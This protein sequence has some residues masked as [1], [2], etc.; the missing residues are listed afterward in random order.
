MSDEIETPAETHPRDPL[1]DVATGLHGQ[2]AR[3]IVEALEAEGITAFAED[4]FTDE[5]F[6]GSMPGKHARVCVP[7]SQAGRAK[8][9]IEHLGPIDESELEKQALEASSD[10]T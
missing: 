7:A 4:A 9:L 5:V 10:E 6:A 1:L 2:E 3:M 8:D